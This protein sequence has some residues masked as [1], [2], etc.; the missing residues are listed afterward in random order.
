MAKTQPKNFSQLKSLIMRKQIHFKIHLAILA[1][2]I[3][4]FGA[5]ENEDGPKPSNENTFLCE[6]HVIKDY[7]LAEVQTLYAANDDY[8]PEMA[9]LLKYGFTVY[10]ITYHTTYLDGSKI[11][12]SGAVLVPNTSEAM[13]VISYQHG[14]II[15]DREAPSNFSESIG[16]YTTPVVFASI[17]HIL[18]LPDYIGYGSTNDLEHPYEH[19]ESLATASRDML[20]AVREFIKQEDEI[21]GTEKLFLTGYSEGASATMA[22]HRLLQENHTEEFTVTATSCVAGAYDKK[23]FMEFIMSTDEPLRYLNF[24]IWVLAAYNEVYAIN[25]PYSYFFNEPYATQIQTQGVFADLSSYNPRQVFKENFINGVK[26]GAETEMVDA[27][28][29]NSYY[30]F[31]PNAPVLL[32]HGTE[33]RFVPCFNSEKAY[34]EMISNGAE[35]TLKKGDGDNHFTIIPDYAKE[36]IDF[37]GR[38]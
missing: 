35:L 17:G 14:T 13:D 3:V 19:G 30:G 25:K 5:C 37:F 26:T 2:I 10:K 8:S 7:D 23:A 38:F 24:Y 1:G 12:A 31:M 18:V 11:K 27:L 4:I 15:Y 34:N 16:I 6:A 22:L 21:K 28:Y 32:V 20:R 29:A 36:T 9:S 33:D